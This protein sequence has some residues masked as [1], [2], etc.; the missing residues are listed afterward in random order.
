M[1]H[2]VLSNWKV[3]PQDRFLDLILIFAGDGE[4][5]EKGETLGLQVRTLEVRDDPW[6]D[7]NC[8]MG[9]LYCAWMAIS[10][11]PR[12]L[13]W[14]SPECKTW[15]SFLTRKTFKRVD[16]C[17]SNILGDESK[18]AVLNANCSSLFIG[19]IAFLLHLR[20]CFVGI[21]QPLNSLLYCTPWLAPNLE[22]AC[23]QRYF[24]SLGAFGSPTAKPLELYTNVPGA[25]VHKF[26]L[27]PL[28]KRGELKKMARLTCK[29]K[30][31]TD[32]LHKSLQK[33]QAYP[34]D[35]SEAIARCCMSLLGVN[36]Q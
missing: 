31:R 29:S 16:G 4:A 6:Q 12:G 2:E 24:T 28:P 14:M 10:L 15:L 7:I 32:G 11:K 8:L 36:Q 5:A 26:L 21:E 9:A 20:G 27:R 17:S 34:S 18:T 3:E 22:N 13:A 19:W 25:L 35:F 30:G 33:S 23:C 1:Q